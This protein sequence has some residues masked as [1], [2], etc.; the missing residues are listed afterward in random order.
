M[1]KALMWYYSPTKNKLIYLKLERILMIFG[2]PA[3]MENTIEI[4]SYSTLWA[5]FPHKWCVAPEFFVLISSHCST[6]IWCIRYGGSWSIYFLVSSSVPPIY[7]CRATENEFIVYYRIW[8]ILS[9]QFSSGLTLPCVGL[10][11][12]AGCFVTAQNYLL[13]HKNKKNCSSSNAVK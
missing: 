2:F 6:Q 4:Y 12:I 5:F 1:T 13:F 9:T 3:N 8:C 11:L 7:N 10:S